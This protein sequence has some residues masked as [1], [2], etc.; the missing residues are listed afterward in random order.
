MMVTDG[1]VLRN[2]VVSTAR[3]PAE[4]RGWKRRMDL[5]VRKFLTALMYALSAPAA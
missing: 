3:E 4:D 1:R 2:P 5:A